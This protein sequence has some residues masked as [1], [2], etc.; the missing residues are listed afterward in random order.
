MIAWDV[1]LVSHEASRTGA[2]RVAINTVE[3]LVQAGL[4]VLVVVRSPGPLMEEFTSIGAT[5]CVEP[6]YT[7]RIL[8]RRFQAGKK[9]AGLIEKWAARTLLQRYRPKRIY[10]NSV[11]SLSYAHEA[12][13]YNTP[14]VVHLHETNALLEG[15]LRRYTLDAKEA[16]KITWIACAH[17]AID[18]VVQRYPGNTVLHWASCVDEN[19]IQKLARSTKP[20]LPENFILGVGK[21]N[22]GKGFDIWLRLCQTLER[23]SE[24]KHICFIWAGEIE[25]NLLEESNL[26]FDI[27]RK[28]F[29]LGELSN[30]YPVMQKALLLTVTSR[31]EASPLVTLEAQALGVPVVAFDVGDIKDQIPPHHL[32]PAED[33]DAL[34]LTVQ[35]VLHEQPPVV[36][37]NN[38]RHGISV[39]RQRTLE[40]LAQN[41]LPRIDT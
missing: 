18:A 15:G 38:S 35:R 3:W 31:A 26:N 10:L 33:E 16:N 28:I 19:N 27:R 39:A 21:G 9:L 40:L 5:V 17:Q 2:P 7:L 8:C 14:T 25:R 30:P 41:T 22:H 29:F 32:V 34:L 6:M 23:N 11:L 36:A 1:M 12:L 20:E 24:F 37:F 4:K 13:N